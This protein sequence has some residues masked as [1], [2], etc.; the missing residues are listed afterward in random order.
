MRAGQIPESAT[1]R[2]FTGNNPLTIALYAFTIAGVTKVP[3]HRN[4]RSK[5]RLSEIE[6]SWGVLF[7]LYCAT[8]EIT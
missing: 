4:I 5:A 7:S 1:I 6:K 2:S 3:P 8:I